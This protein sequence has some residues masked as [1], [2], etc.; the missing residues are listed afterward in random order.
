MFDC[1]HSM[2]LSLPLYAKAEQP[3]WFA[4]IF[5][6]VNFFQASN[7]KRP[8]SDIA[9][10]MLSEPRT[11]TDNYNWMRLFAQV[12]SYESAHAEHCCAA[13]DK[14]GRLLATSSQTFGCLPRSKLFGAGAVSGSFI[15]AKL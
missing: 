13:W 12:R 3:P 14:S 7:L 8:N 2:P 10:S 4:T 6:T 5:Y 15:V 1:V 9:A 11:I